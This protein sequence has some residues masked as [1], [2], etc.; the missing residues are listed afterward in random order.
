MQA[1]QVIAAGAGLGAAL[2]VLWLVAPSSP[3][4]TGEP[5]PGGRTEA[6]RAP[7]RGQTHQQPDAPGGPAAAPDEGGDTRRA[8]GPAPTAQRARGNMPPPGGRGLPTSSYRAAAAAPQEGQPP[9]QEEGGKDEAGDFDDRGAEDEAN[10]L[11]DHMTDFL[12]AV[13]PETSGEGLARSCTSDGRS[14]TFEGPITDDSFM[15][16]WFAAH[17]DGDIDLQGITFSELAFEDNDEGRT[18]T[19]TATAP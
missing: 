9:G 14:C 17:A 11:E 3:R 18:F 5:P 4:A 12:A 16:R 8:Q 13:V 19:F 10:W 2:F 1:R 6:K 7:D 15:K